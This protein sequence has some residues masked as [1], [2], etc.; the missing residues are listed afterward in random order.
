M[1][2]TKRPSRTTTRNRINRL[3]GDTI[4]TYNLEVPL[5]KIFE[6]VSTHGGLVVDEAGD[7]WSGFLCGS[8]GQT[9]MEVQFDWMKSMYLHISWYKMGSER[10]E[11]T[12]YIS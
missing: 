9:H 7:P 6:C 8:D 1:T 2:Q 11:V 10:Y 12:V 3:I 4:P 5:D